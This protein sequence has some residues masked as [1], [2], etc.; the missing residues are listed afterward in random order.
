MFNCE[1]I[2]QGD[3]VDFGSYGKLYVCSVSGDYFRVTDKKKDRYNSDASG[4]N[5]RKKYAKTIIKEG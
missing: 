2:Q 4:W 5:I 1:K 3:L